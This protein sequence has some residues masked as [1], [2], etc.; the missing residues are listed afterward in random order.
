MMAPEDNFVSATVAVGPNGLLDAS[1]PV[2][3][4]VVG[5]APLRWPYRSRAQQ[6]RAMRAAAAAAHSET[7]PESS[8]ASEDDEKREDCRWETI[9]EDNMESG[10]STSSSISRAQPAQLPDQNQVADEAECMITKEWVAARFARMFVVGAVGPAASGPDEE[11]VLT[12]SNKLV[13]L[14][15]AYVGSEKSVS[16]D[17]ID[18]LSKSFGNFDRVVALGWLLGD[19][20]GLPLM[21]RVLAH[22]LGLAAKYLAGKTEKT[23]EKTTRDAKRAAGRAGV[24]DA[25]RRKLIDEAETQVEELLR[26]PAK[27]L[28]H[29]LGSGF[30]QLPAHPAHESALVSLSR[31]MMLPCL[32]SR[33]RRCLQ[34]R[35]WS[36]EQSSF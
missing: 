6:E 8:N 11:I 32:C 29:S 27:E 13:A 34:L 20:I 30:N 3:E 9:K 15:W 4:V 35:R 17:K 19:A 14:V 1:Q 25:M 5:R 22:K 31:L 10:D 18:E 12:I 28:M 2:S 24:E 23:N 33:R 26:A 21:E 36:S 7:S 16:K